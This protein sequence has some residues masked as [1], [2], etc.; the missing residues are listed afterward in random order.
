MTFVGEGA[1]SRCYGFKLG[2]DDLVIRFGQ[3]AEDFLKD[4]QASLF[5]S[6][7]LPIPELLTIGKA[8]N[9]YYAVSRRVYGKVDGHQ[10]TG[11]FDWGCAIF[12]DHLYDLA[13]FDFWSPWYP[14]L[15]INI[16]HQGLEERWQQADMIIENK[17]ARL[18]ACTLYIGLDHLAY[19]AFQ[20]DVVNLAATAERMKTL[21]KELA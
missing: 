18:K 3:F 20:E 16:L 4:K 12:G 2:Q 8:L 7:E 14:D 6:P 9:G 11:I 21:I 1:W 10:I 17:S 15:D 5:A 19:N 13:W